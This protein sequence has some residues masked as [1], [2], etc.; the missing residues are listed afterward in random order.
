MDTLQLI[1]EPTRREILQMVW[2]DE[3]TAG[4][5]ADRFD[6]TFGAVSQHLAKLREAGLVEVRPEGTSRFYRAN[7]DRLAPFRAM[8]EAM[9]TSRLDQLAAAVEE[10]VVGK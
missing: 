10:A 2:L 9:W 3:L 6:V 7:H 5:I 1:A 4:T 8:L